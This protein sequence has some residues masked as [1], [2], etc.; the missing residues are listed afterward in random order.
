VEKDGRSV[1]ALSLPTRIKRGN[2]RCLEA[3][4]TAG[5]A[6]VETS[7]AALMAELKATEC[8]AGKLK[9]TFVAIEVGGST[10]SRDSGA[11]SWRS[12]CWLPM[13]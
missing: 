2:A 11:T 1:R 5:I 9:G 10:S 8:F 6:E 3:G 13:A 12:C 7:L 4:A